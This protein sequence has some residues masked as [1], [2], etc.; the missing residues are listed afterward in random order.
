MVGIQTICFKIW[1]FLPNF[2]WQF[3]LGFWDDDDGFSSNL[4]LLINGDSDGNVIATDTP[5]SMAGFDQDCW[6]VLE[7]L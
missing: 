5:L 1:S 7:L 3:N 2:D 4:D 6:K